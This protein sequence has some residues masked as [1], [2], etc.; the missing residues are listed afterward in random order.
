[1]ASLSRNPHASLSDDEKRE[2]R[3][4]VFVDV[5]KKEEAFLTH[6]EDLARY[7]ATPLLV[8]DTPFKRDCMDELLTDKV[9]SINCLAL[10]M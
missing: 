7:F 9:D 10:P 2:K 5:V 6:L 8:R 1:M 3:K 4:K